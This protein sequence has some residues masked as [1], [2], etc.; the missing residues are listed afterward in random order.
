M[1]GRAEVGPRAREKEKEEGS[2]GGRRSVV[3]PDW[4]FYLYTCPW[5]QTVLKL[6]EISKHLAG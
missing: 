3:C 4:R 5:H 2:V 6:S 1:R